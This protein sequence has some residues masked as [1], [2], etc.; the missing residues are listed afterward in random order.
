MA[1]V[2]PLQQHIKPKAELVYKVCDFVLCL[3]F[4][5]E[6]QE[7]WTVDSCREW[8]QHLGN[9]EQ[10]FKIMW[11]QNVPAWER[12]YSFGEYIGASQRLSVS[13]LMFHVHCLSWHFP[14]VWCHLESWLDLL[15][16]VE[17]LLVS[18]LPPRSKER[19]ITEILHSFP[20]K[21]F[22][23]KAGQILQNI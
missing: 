4:C 23:S 15:G 9:G 2:G 14:T 16:T 10:I 18:A 17:L 20:G 1:V 8:G 22:L 3:H 21:I 11:V 12:N 5:Y 7:E 13:P 6:V 19:S